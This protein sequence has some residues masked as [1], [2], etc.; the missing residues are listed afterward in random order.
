MEVLAVIEAGGGFGLG[1][2]SR[3]QRLIAA[4]AEH[5]H[6][7]RL[8]L[9]AG[10]ADF[11]VAGLDG[12]LERRLTPDDDMAAALDG[13]LAVRPADWLLLDGYGLRGLSPSGP[14]RMLVDDLGDVPVAADIVLNQNV[15]DDTLY[16]RPGFTVGRVLAGPAYALVDPAYATAR[17]VRDGLARVLVT[18]GGTDRAN[19]TLAAVQAASVL[20]GRLDIDVVA[21]PGYVHA[22]TL[23]ATSGAHR[24]RVHRGVGSLVSLMAQADLV[25][26]STS[27]TALEACCAG[28]PAVAAR[29]VANQ[30]ELAATLRRTG[31]CLCVDS[32]AGLAAALAEAA[33]PALRCRLA[34]AAERLVDGQ[35]AARVARALLE[36]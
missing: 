18:F 3:S 7:L 36:G 1:H 20:P 11:T 23:P 10:S 30:A 29:M 33:D 27:V 19:A 2:L 15:L 12:V 22:D 25:I 34:R 24:V 13:A 28:V 6:R 21:G 17:R 14:R 32:P 4:L 9:R 5:G 35:G 26:C 8:W 16:R 31:A